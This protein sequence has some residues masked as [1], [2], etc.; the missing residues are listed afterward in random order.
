MD[1]GQLEVRDAQG[2]LLRTVPLVAGTGLM[3]EDVRALSPGIYFV[4]LVVD[5]HLLG[6][7]KFNIAR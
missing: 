4:C 7:A 3:E 5:Q 6:T 2:R 1:Q